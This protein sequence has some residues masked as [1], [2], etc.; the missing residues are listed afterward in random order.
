VRYGVLAAFLVLAAAACGGGGTTSAGPLSVTDVVHRVQPSVVSVI[1]DEGE[2]SGVI[3]S[4]DGAI[5]TNEHVIH[6]S[7]H[8]QVVFANGKRVP[9]KVE[10]ADPFYDLAVLRVARKHL[11]AATFAKK[12]PEVGE[13]AVAL[14]NPFGFERSVSGGIVSGLHRSLPEEKV[15]LNSDADLIQTD[16]AISPGNSGGALVNTD[17]EVIGINASYIPPST[18]A[19]E[20]G[21]AIPADTV[22]DV[23]SDLVAH[24]KPEHPYVGIRPTE[25]W[26]ELIKHFGIEAKSGVL[27]VQVVKGSPADKA[28]LAAG[29]VIGSIDGKRTATVGDY[30]GIMRREKPGEKVKLGLT[31]YGN[32]HSVVVK[33]GEGG[34]AKPAKA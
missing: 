19:V 14:G 29:D 28:G 9:A 22:K 10:G 30:V 4:A 1:V 2:G 8:V 23:V 34:P 15:K 18:G 11:P 20:I 33:V 32:D 26:P 31:G 5:V 6:G 27:V 16:A 25:L 21:F 24:R 7:K 12:T 13:G 17:G 3:W